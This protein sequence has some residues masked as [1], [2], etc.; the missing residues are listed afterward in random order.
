M[1]FNHRKGIVLKSVPGKQLLLIHPETLKNYL[2]GLPANEAGWVT[3]QVQEVKKPNISHD[4]THVNDW[5]NRLT[6]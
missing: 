6:K 1:G 2:L 4:I 3:F 5:R